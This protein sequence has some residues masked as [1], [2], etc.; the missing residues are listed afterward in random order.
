MNLEELQRAVF[1]V[2]RQPLTGSEGMRPRLPDG[3]ATNDVAER[4]IKPNDRLTSFDRLEIYNRQYWFRLLAS[5]AEDFPGLRAIIGEKQFQKLATAYLNDCPSESW[6]LRDVPSRLEAWLREHLD[7]VYGV[8]RIAIDMVKL[9]WA[10]IDAHDKLELPRMDAA[11]LGTLGEDP[12]F[13]LQP[14]LR[15]LNLSYPVDDLLLSI[16]HRDNEKADIASNA[17]MER[18]RRNKIRRSSLPKPKKVYL[19]V[20]RKDGLIYYKRLEPEAFALLRELRQGKPL[21]AAIEA[22]VKWTNRSVEKITG[23]LH[24]WFA[25]W[26]ELGWFCLPPLEPNDP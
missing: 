11:A 17:V 4:L 2:I 10:E 7:F 24:D 23:N 15:L 3:R 19:A 22:S 13:H 25:D 21:S 16:V 14:H 5:I 8:E 1:E 18:P 20:H 12:V 9:E 6:T 26:S